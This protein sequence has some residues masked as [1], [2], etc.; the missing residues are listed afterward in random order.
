MDLIKEACNSSEDSNSPESKKENRNI[1]NHYDSLL[2]SKLFSDF[3]IICY[4][5]H[6]AK[7][8]YVHKIVLSRIQYFKNLFVSEC[9]RE[10]NE[11]QM[12]LDD[13]SYNVVKEMLRF[14]YTGSVQQLSTLASDLLMAAN[15]VIYYNIIC[16]NVFFNKYDIFCLFLVVWYRWF[17]NQGRKLPDSSNF[18]KPRW[19]FANFR[20]YSYG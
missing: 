14:I 10:N 19:E 1:L 8:I 6:T 5:D 13:F 12:T 7:E 15:K 11:N 2:D 16:F 17:E 3:K 20:P 9:Y 4:A 18:H